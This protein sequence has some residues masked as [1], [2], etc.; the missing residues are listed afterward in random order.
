M[1]SGYQLAVSSDEAVTD[2]TTLQGGLR[3]GAFPRLKVWAMMF[4]RF[5]VNPTAPRRYSLFSASRLPA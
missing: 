4:N 1:L 2:A 5:A 3:G